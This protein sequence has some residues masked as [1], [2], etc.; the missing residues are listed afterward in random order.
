M[1]FV[2]FSMSETSLDDACSSDVAIELAKSV[3]GILGMLDDCWV[4][5]SPSVGRYL[6]L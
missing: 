5:G 6:L 1:F 3:P 2:N 4:D